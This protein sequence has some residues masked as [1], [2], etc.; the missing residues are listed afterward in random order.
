M[1]YDLAIIGSGPA[2]LGASV[3][4]SRYGIKNIIIGEVSGGLTTTTFDIGNWLGTQKITG[5]N[6]AQKSADHARSY[7]VEIIA[8]KV[9]KINK[10][11][12]GFDISVNDGKKIKARSILL[13][14]GTKHRKLGISGEDKLSGKGVSYCAT[15]DGYFYKGKTV[16]VVGGGDSAAE[17]A[18]FLSGIAEKIYIIYRKDKLRAE[19]FWK[20]S[21]ESNS[22]IKV[23]YNTNVKEIKGENKVEELI[24]DSSFKKSNALK[25]DGIFIEIGADP[26]TD[27]AKNIGAQLDEE[28]YIKIGPDGKTTETG[29][30]AAGDITTGSNK[31]KQIITAA[32]EGAIA[33]NSIQQYL[34][35]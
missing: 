26:S 14:M 28:G 5:M 16:A 15:C 3:Y 10:T 30:W 32:A 8:G 35:K 18:V 34:K 23:I 6:F 1:Q 31:F 22:K 20:K 24:L 27:L 29:V 17:A 12:E 19:S 11:G 13:A 9:D 33:A 7:G 21:V 25:T 4:T 2:G